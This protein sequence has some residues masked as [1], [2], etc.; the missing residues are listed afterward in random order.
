M[1]RQKSIQNTLLQE[2]RLN[3]WLEEDKKLLLSGT[4]VKLT[5]FD[6][7]LTGNFE[8]NVKKNEI[9]LRKGECS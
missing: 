7:F 6:K 2:N 9:L 3:E 8:V 1:R 5:D 4:L